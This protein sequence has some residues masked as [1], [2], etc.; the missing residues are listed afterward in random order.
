[1]AAIVW[2]LLTPLRTMAPDGVLVTMIVGLAIVIVLAEFDR[3]SLPRQAWQVPRPWYARYGP[4]RAYAMYG[5]WLGAGLATNVT[6]AVEYLVFVGAG[7]MMPL[8]PALLAGALFGL[9]RTVLVGPV[10]ATPAAS[11][12]LTNL[13]RR[14]ERL[15]IIV[16]GCGLALLVAVGLIALSIG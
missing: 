3:V 8:G 12:F 5:F 7:L 15:L 13:Y 14:H 4:T 16:G 2:I 9:G 11:A 10:A 6:Y 1:M